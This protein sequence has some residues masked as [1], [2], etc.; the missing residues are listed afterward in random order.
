MPNTVKNFVNNNHSAKSIPSLGPSIKKPDSMQNLITNNNYLKNVTNLAPNFHPIVNQ[1]PFAQNVYYGIR[2]PTYNHYNMNRLYGNAAK[3]DTP[4]NNNPHNGSR[5]KLETR[6]MSNQNNLENNFMNFFHPPL[7]QPT[8][9][10]APIVERKYNLIGVE[11]VDP[12]KYAAQYGSELVNTSK[13]PN[14]EI[15]KWAETNKNYIFPYNSRLASRKHC[16]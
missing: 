9:Q 1:H 13:L 15:T 3:H 10:H 4:F 11:E 5:P 16:K 6:F 12:K 8:M 14:L 7:P 2:M